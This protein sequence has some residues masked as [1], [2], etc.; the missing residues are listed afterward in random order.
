MLERCSSAHP[1]FALTSQFSTMHTD[2]FPCPG[3]MLL[4]DLEIDPTFQ[5]FISELKMNLCLCRF[6]GSA[7]YSEKPRTRVVSPF[8]PFMRHKCPGARTVTFSEIF[9]VLEPIF[10]EL[11]HHTSITEHFNFSS[12]H[13]HGYLL[14]LSVTKFVPP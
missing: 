8:R 3:G 14:Q 6:V 5:I 7:G 4:L 1:S 11:K 12:F 9:F 2:T 10:C 13:G